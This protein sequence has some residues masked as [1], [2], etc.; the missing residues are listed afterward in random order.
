MV[1]LVSPKAKKKKKPSIGRTV[2]RMLTLRSRS[3]VKPKPKR[4]KPM[5]TTKDDDKKPE[6]KKGKEADP[7]ATP[8]DT[9][10]APSQLPS[11]VDP[12]AGKEKKEEKK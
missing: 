4:R 10:Y 12:E 8:P 9:V 2:R 1:R 11:D 3:K 6:A 7:M 5:T